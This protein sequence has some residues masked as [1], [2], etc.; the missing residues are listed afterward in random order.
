MRV[1]VRRH[2]PSVPPGQLPR[3]RGSTRPPSLAG[4]GDPEGVEGAYR[5][6]AVPSSLSI[7][8]VR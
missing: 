8:L 5:R 2:A 4:E 6:T 1:Q 3:E 7:P